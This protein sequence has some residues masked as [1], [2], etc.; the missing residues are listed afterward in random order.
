MSALIDT[1]TMHQRRAADPAVSAFVAASA[2]SGKTTVL[3]DRVL[4]LL[5]ND[6]PPERLL[7]L[8]FTKTAA[9]EMANR[10][11]KTL[12]AWAV[13]PADKLAKTL[14]NLT[15][16]VPNDTVKRTAKHLFTR[17]LE[18]PGGLKIMTIH[19]FCQSVLKRFPLEA[20]VS[21]NFDIL[22]ET[23]AAVF[24]NKAIAQT[25]ADPALKPAVET[26]AAYVSAEKLPALLQQ[27]LE[28][29]LPD[30]FTMWETAINAYFDLTGWDEDR[31]ITACGATKETFDTLKKTYLTDKET[32]RRK[33]TDQ[34]AETADLVYTAVQK[35]KAIRLKEASSALFSVA[36]GIRA[37]Y[38]Q[39]KHRESVLDYDDL[40]AKTRA[41]LEQNAMA[42][43][44]LFKLDGGLDHIL[45]DEAQDTNT[46][47]WSV[48]KTLADEFFAG[49]QDTPHPRTI[50]VVGDKKQSIYGFQGADPAEFERMHR[51]FSDRVTAARQRFETIP[52]NASFRSTNAVLALVNQ[53]LACPAAAAGVL[54]EQETAPHVSTRTG[55]AGLVEIWPLEKAAESDAPE[56]WKPPVERIA[57]PS[58]VTRLA[59]KITH[60]IKEMLDNGDVLPSQ[61]R[62]VCPGDFLILVQRRRQ[63]TH[64]LVRL[65]K[66]LNIPVA[67]LDRL[68]LSDHI[69]VQDLIALMRF[70][71]LPADDLNL[72]CLLKSP[73]VGITEDQ[74]M[75]AA[76]DRGKCSLFQAL[77]DTNHPVLERLQAFRQ[78]N[79]LPP[80]EFLTRVLGEFGG[81]KA[82]VARLGHEVHEAL[83]ELMNLAL[84]Y[85]QTAAPSLQG[86]VYWLG[87]RAIEIK[88]DLENAADAVRI[89]TVHAS[90]GLQGNIVF[91]PDT[92]FVPEQMPAFIKTPTGAPLWLARSALKTPAVNALCDTITD[93]DQAEYRRLLYVALTRACDRLYIC[94]YQTKRPVKEGC[95]YQLIGRALDS[96]LPPSGMENI[97][98]A[99]A[100]N[101]AD[102]VW[103]THTDTGLIRLTNS[104]DKVITSTTAPTK[105]AVLSPALPNWLYQPAPSEP[106]PTRPLMPSRPT[107]DDGNDHLLPPDQAYALRRGT[108]LHQLLQYLPDIAPEKRREAANKRCPADI[109]VPDQ[110]FQVLDDPRFAPLFGPGSLAEVPLVGLVG[111]Q[112][113]SGQADR[114]VILKD[115]VIVIDYKT[116]RRVPTS[117]AHIPVAYKNQMNAYKQ[118]L[119]EIFPD[120]LICAYLLWLE[121]LTIT[122]VE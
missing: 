82:F 118:L 86:F 22:D 38:A 81:R 4:R 111:N 84:T 98:L 90:K 47:Q 3:T 73:L 46:Q 88:R 76:M 75:H 42:A 49:L 64:E 96:V 66:E 57:E 74:L 11:T 114:L 80:F 6:T 110:L 117:A 12:R 89:M 13:M 78:L 15:G 10:I 113:V 39:L 108:F 72:A 25:L 31:L 120:K 2:G 37:A 29:D 40:I 69:A 45:V 71:L 101:P 61:N 58:A 83:D 28:T 62:A 1:I 109:T 103:L 50:F 53:V 92:T 106:T 27:T 33:L 41:L 121:N 24:L 91:L 20:G 36:K 77:V 107:D 63:L 105:S 43:W 65:F 116:N 18:T 5:L 93:A 67:G 54:G 23:A 68:T 14:E 16:Q 34:Q 95:W 8:T 97:L 55:H 122:E 30:D 52:L 115:K 79:A 17:T 19:G 35:I 70:V 100:D 60:K 7:C 59:Q 104:G 102:A 44:V 112:V 119:K 32:I 85:E 87:A 9:A 51:F 56:S 21:P 26:L 94:G 48:I 99:P